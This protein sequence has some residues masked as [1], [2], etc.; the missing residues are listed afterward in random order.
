MYP[1]LGSIEA[2][3]I[4]YIIEQ[5]KIF[6]VSILRLISVSLSLSLSEE[7]SVLFFPPVFFPSF[8]L[9]L[10]FFTLGALF[11]DPQPH[12]PV[13]FLSPSLPLRLHLPQC[14]AHSLHPSLS[15]SLYLSLFQTPLLFPVSF[16]LSSLHPMLTV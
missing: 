3:R 9:C 1:T 15:V 7:L 6:Q 16:S 4:I 13:F 10:F 5:L 14:L 8:F 2:L 12:L 11:G